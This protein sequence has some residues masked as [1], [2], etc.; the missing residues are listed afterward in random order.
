MLAIDDRAGRFGGFFAAEG[1]ITAL[2]AA[3]LASDDTVGASN[4]EPGRVEKDSDRV[5]PAVAVPF[6]SF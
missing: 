2:E 6:S 5:M 1:L 3:C 4:V